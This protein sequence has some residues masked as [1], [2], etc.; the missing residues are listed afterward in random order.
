MA[1]RFPRIKLD[2][3]SIATALASPL[4]KIG[5]PRTTPRLGVQTIKGPAVCFAATSKY[6]ARALKTFNEKVY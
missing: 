6:E 4:A 1:R 2:G 3:L 5:P